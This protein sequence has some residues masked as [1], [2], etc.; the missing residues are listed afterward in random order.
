M[1]IKLIGCKSTMN[2]V[3]WL[4]IDKKIDCEF[5]DYSFHARPGKLRKKLQKLID[6]SQDYSLIILTYSRCSNSLVGLVSPTVP[7]LFPRT[8]DCI[9][10]MLGSNALHI[11]LF[12]ENAATYYFSQGWLDYGRTP[13]SEFLEYKEQY[14]ETEAFNLIN[15]LYGR[16]E[17]AVLII[18]PGMK[19][20]DYYRRKVGKIAN[21][22]GWIMG[23]VYG[24]IDLLASVL[25]GERVP[26]SVYIEPGREVTLDMLAESHRTGAN[27]AIW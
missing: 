12:K 24:E 4:G 17:K 3:R 6:A 20:I 2:E 27:S 11:K 15:A 18:T 23:E 10:L 16:Y 13:Y 8:H 26:E 25:K 19:D 5:L 7:M 14:G 21:F 9:G 1:K 22:F